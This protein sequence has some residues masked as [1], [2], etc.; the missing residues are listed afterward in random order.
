MRENVRDTLDGVL[1]GYQRITVPAI[2]ETTNF[3]MTSLNKR[4]TSSASPLASS[5]DITWNHR[6]SDYDIFTAGPASLDS[7]T[8]LGFTFF[9]ISE[10][11]HLDISRNSGTLKA[12]L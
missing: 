2:F 8:E 7:L 11:H 1:E 9:D 5:F 3:Q 12:R 10:F 6:R 4:K